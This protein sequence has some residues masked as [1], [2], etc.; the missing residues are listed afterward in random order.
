MT[1]L[2]IQF[3]LHEWLANHVKGIQY[4]RQQYLPDRSARPFFRY[5]MPWRQRIYLLQ[6]GVIISL[7]GLV[8]SS[9]GLFFAHIV[10]RAIIATR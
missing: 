1:K 5:P 9:L 6:F 4:P 7:T 3:R 2:S 10:V 8:M